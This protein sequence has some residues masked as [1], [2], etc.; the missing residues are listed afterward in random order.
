M[1]EKN[2]EYSQMRVKTLDEMYQVIDEMIPSVYTYNNKTEI[3]V[4]DCINN[5]NKTFSLTE[6]EISLLNSEEDYLEKQRHL[7]TLYKQKSE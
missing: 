1:A 5:S 7:F 4:V 3:Y 6:D 2:E